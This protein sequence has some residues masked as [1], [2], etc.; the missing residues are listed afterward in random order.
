MFIKLGI[1]YD[2]NDA[3]QI[4]GS[5]M[6][7]FRDSAY[8]ASVDLAEEK[9]TFL[10]YD[11][12]EFAKSEFISKWFKDQESDVQEKFI[13]NGIRNSFLLTVAPVGSGSIIA[14]VSSGLEPI[15][16]TSYSRRVRQQDG[17]KFKTY[18]TYPKIIK[19]LFIDDVNLPIFVTT[20]HD[21][22]PFYR[23]RLQSI[24]QRYIDN[25]ISSTIN[26]PSDTTIDTV[27]E[28]YINA[29][30]EGLKSVTVYRDGCREGVLITDKKPKIEDKEVE[31]RKKRPITLESKTYKIP[32]GPDRK[33][34]ITISGFEDDPGRP[35]EMFIQGYGPDDAEIKSIAVLVSALLRQCKD[36][37]FL[38]DHLGKIDSPKQGAIWHDKEAH[39]RYYI[40]SVPR[41][42]GIALK[43]F[44]NNGNDVIKEHV[45][46]EEKLNGAQECLKCHAI[47][48][49][50]EEGC[51]K[52]LECGWAKC[53]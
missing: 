51:E 27:A 52:C 14:Q 24:I 48:L 6:R 37:D 12:K 53:F 11:D 19:D 35:F 36:I 38:I 47:S 42:V 5:I 31:V 3:I 32:D 8:E 29:W 20:S 25:S 45:V 26:L 1:Q 50:K 9:G 13:K 40:N 33:L 10:W 2:S 41:A 39:K 23:I 43:K 18:K 7:V 44:I 17:E 22:D 15:F 28:I 4:T 30:K 21:I 34:Y 49:I 46:D 16:A